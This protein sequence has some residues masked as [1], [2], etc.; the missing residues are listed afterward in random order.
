MNI[1]ED[2]TFGG[3]CNFL[4]PVLLPPNVIGNNQANVGDPLTAKK[5]WHRYNAPY[6]QNGNAAS[7][8]DRRVVYREHGTE[9]HIREL[10]FGSRTASTG[11]TTITIDVLKNGVTVLSAPI[12]LDVGNVAYI[13]ELGTVTVPD[14]V[15]GDVLEVNVTISGAPGNGVFGYIIVDSK[16]QATP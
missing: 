3:T 10:G 15:A 6:A 5:V 16:P 13:T 4:K 11:A 14:M 7:A 8:A 12:V 1:N 9:G 2:C